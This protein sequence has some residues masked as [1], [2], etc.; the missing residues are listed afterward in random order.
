MSGWMLGCKSLAWYPYLHDRPRYRK[1][2]DPRDPH[3]PS[4]IGEDTARRS[5]GKFLILIRKLYPPIE[6][7]DYFIMF[8][9]GTCVPGETTLLWQLLPG[10]RFDKTTDNLGSHV[11]RKA[12]S[13]IRLASQCI[14]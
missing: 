14:A 9:K 8:R 4:A 1:F 6:T 2:S 5:L 13:D 12:V 7:Q 11:I 3:W 10:A